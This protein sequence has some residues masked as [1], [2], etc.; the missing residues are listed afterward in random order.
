MTNKINVFNLMIELHKKYKNSILKLIKEKSDI[1]NQL[2][3]NKKKLSIFLNDNDGFYN[4]K[5]MSENG[6]EFFKN[7]YT[8]NNKIINNIFNIDT[9]IS[10]L[11]N[12]ISLLNKKMVKQQ[13]EIEKFNFLAD[14]EKKIILNKINRDLRKI[15][16]EISSITA[17]R[18]KK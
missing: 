12:E 5:T 10:V 3:E 2:E 8:Y 9:K 13:L 17:E 16:D 1:K 18:Q 11:K 7:N 4:F 14:K 15:E 6:I